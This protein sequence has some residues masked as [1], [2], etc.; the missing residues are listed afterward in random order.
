MLCTG[1]RPS[2]ARCAP[3]Y[4]ITNYGQMGSWIKGKTKTGEDQE[5]P[6]P[7]QLMPWIAAWPAIRPA[8]S[9]PYL[10]PGQAYGQPLS[11]AVVRLRW[12]ELRLILGI[13]GLWNYD[14][15]RTLACYLSNELHHDDVTIRAILNHYDGSAL[16]HYCFKSFDSLTGPMQ[17]Y[18][19]WLWG[20]RRPADPLQ[21]PYSRRAADHVS[22]VRPSPKEIV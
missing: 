21:K 9:N 20:L 2:E 17:Q 7:T 14:L 1:C 8:T 11:A 6:L 10:F 18:A 3:L 15:R 12:H 16:G 5:L 22:L 4:A 13:T 19:D